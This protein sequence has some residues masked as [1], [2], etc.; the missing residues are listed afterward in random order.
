M[1]ARLGPRR[2]GFSMIE[3]A[4]VC[5]LVAVLAAVAWP[6]YRSHLLRAGRF[7]AQQTLTRVQIAQEQRRNNFGGYAS[8]LASLAG[9]AATSPQGLYRI[10]LQSTGPDSYRALAQAQGAQAS[11][12][13]CAEI[14]LDVSLG[15]ASVGPAPACWNR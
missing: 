6:A 14:T 5:A 4:A 13:A 7:D 15:F 3:C 12:R 9:V 1:A 10:R 11:D 8:D 2:R